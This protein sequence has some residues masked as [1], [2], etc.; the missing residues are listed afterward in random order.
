ILMIRCL[1]IDDE[2]H[3]IDVIRTYCRRI[4]YLEVLGEFTDPREAVAYLDAESHSVDL[5]FLD[6]EMPRF[7]GIDFLKAYTF[8]N[9][10]LITAYTEY[11]LESYQYGVV[12][13][14][15]K[16]VA[17]ERFS[18]AVKRVHERQQSK[19]MA[20]RRENPSKDSIY[21]KTDR[22]KIEK[23]ALQDIVYI[24][25]A[26]NFSVIRSIKGAIVSSLRLKE[27]EEL[28]PS[29]RFVRIHKSYII[30]MDY[31]EA[32]EGKNIQLKNVDRKFVIGGAYKPDFLRIIEP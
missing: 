22:Y 7:S 1:I 12:D 30:H 5:V 16:P 24:Q 19:I 4:P 3:A 23:V 9:V 21:V 25:G 26:K 20:Y 14:L 28:R 17:F 13:Y 15:L 29:E 32:L 2:Q 10:I 27:L 6:I 31:L 18:T 11:A 8:P